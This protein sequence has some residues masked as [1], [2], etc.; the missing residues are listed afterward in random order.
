MSVAIT[1]LTS[2]IRCSTPKPL[3][4]SHSLPLRSSSFH[5]RLRP[6]PPPLRRSSVATFFSDQPQ[7]PPSTITEDNNPLLQDFNFPPFDV[8]DASHVRP[9]MRALLNKLDDDLEELEKT[10]EPSWSKL[11]EPLERIVDR[12]SVVWGAINHLK[13]VKDTPELRSAIEEIQDI[14]S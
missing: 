1:S 13:A 4:T 10:V 7:P 6:S 2:L 14:L 3:L 8:I 12:L 5:F 9:G 11:V